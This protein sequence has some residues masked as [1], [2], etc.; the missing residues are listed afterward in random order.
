MKKY[1]IFLL[2]LLM[3]CFTACEPGWGEPD[4]QPEF[5][6]AETTEEIY[7]EA[8]A[9][10]PVIYLYPEEETEVTVTLNFAGELT[11][12]Y[13]AYN[14]GWRVTAAPDGT[15]TD[16]NGRE[17]GYLFWEGLSDTE[18][19][20]TEG[21]VVAGSDTE[22][23]LEEK[24]ALLG[25]TEK[26]AADFITYWLPRMQKN[27]YNLISFQG[28]AYTDAAELTITPQP[29]SLIRVFMVFRALE[30]PIELPQQTLSSPVRTGFTA[31]E[32]GGTEVCK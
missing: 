16:E 19:D 3:L 13:P 30:E 1:L 22:A 31:V 21:F 5:C 7:D 28:S 17:Y 32:W 10:K 26:E 25:L 29:D 15:L 11:C 12:T 6:P 20:M 18:Y 9:E 24:L 14:D 23:F 2:S 27:P 4:N 8:P